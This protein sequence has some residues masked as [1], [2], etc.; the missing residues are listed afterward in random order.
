MYFIFQRPVFYKRLT[1]SSLS[2]LTFLKIDVSEI[3]KIKYLMLPQFT[4]TKQTKN[5]FFLFL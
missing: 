2:R 4:Y 5:T 3:A 1:L